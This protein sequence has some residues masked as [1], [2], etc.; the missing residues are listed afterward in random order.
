MKQS[1]LYIYKISVDLDH[2]TFVRDDDRRQIKV[3]S[4]KSFLSVN[5]VTYTEM[6]AGNAFYILKEYL[7]LW[8]LDSVE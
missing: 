2:F 6:T 8:A 1:R 5:Y 3:A 7:C 4:H